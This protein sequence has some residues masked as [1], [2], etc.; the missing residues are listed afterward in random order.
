MIRAVIFDLDGTLIDALDGHVL[1]LNRAFAVKGYPKQKP[2]EIYK[3]YGETGEEI[4]RALLKKPSID[5]EVEEIA[6]LKREFYKETNGIYIKLLPGVAELIRMLHSKKIPL[7]VASSA[8]RRGIDEALDKTGIAKYFSVIVSSDD[9]KNSKPNPE[10]FLK[11][12][13][14]LKIAPKKCLV[15]EDSLWGVMAAIAAEMKCIAVATGTA[16]KA[17]LKK[18]EPNL[19]IDSMNVIHISKI[20]AFLSSL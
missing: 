8:N 1:T 4:I 11:A 12:A 19:V 14:A 5:A 2:K 13:K 18:L 20:D 3:Y 17:D 6:R 9:V 15:F 7:A 16:T 10:I